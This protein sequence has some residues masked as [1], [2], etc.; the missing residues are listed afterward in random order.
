[1]SAEA[2]ATA[3]PAPAAALRT[4]DR[5]ALAAALTT[6]L[7]WAS[8]F[9]GIRAAMPDLSAGALALGR[10]L[11]G[12]VALG[13]I[14]AIRREGLPPREAWPGIAGVRAAVVRRLQRRAERG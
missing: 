6:V 1:M 3:P 5:L 4:V 8:A 2:A 14:L 11:V 9:V 12:S 10:L 7:L 13:A